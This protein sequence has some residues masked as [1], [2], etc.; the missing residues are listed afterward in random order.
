MTNDPVSAVAA[1]IAALQTTGH[2]VDQDPRDDAPTS[3]YLVDGLPVHI[4]A[5]T[6]SWHAPSSSVSIHH[7]KE[8]GGHGCPMVLYRETKVRGWPMDEM[9]E[10]VEKIVCEVKTIRQ[11]REAS[12]IEREA[13][14]RRASLLAAILNDHDD[15]KKTIDVRIDTMNGRALLTVSDPVLLAVLLGALRAM[16]TETAEQAPSL[17]PITAAQLAE[18]L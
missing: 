16:R 3:R 9:V 12:R 1:L 15:V 13:C 14:S 7:D 11:E 18:V 5:S 8:I 2:V 6:C 17:A 10:H 4:R